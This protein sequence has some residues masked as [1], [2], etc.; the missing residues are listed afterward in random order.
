[1]VPIDD[2]NEEQYLAANPDVAAAVRSGACPSGQEHYALYGIRENRPLS[3]N[4]NPIARVQMIRSQTLD[5]RKVEFSGL[6]HAG[7]LDAPAGVMRETRGLLPTASCGRS[8]L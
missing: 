6:C 7:R 4:A 3:C 8:S 2:F 5:R 1:M